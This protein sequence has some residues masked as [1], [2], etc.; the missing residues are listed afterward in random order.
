MSK[1]IPYLYNLFNGISAPSTLQVEATNDAKPLWPNSI[2]QMLLPVTEAYRIQYEQKGATP[3]GVFWSSTKNVLRRFEILCRIFHC[4]DLNKGTASIN[5]LGCGYGALFDY[6]EHHPV[7]INGK[8]MGYEI[9]KALLDSCNN[10]INDPR[11]S[12]HHSMYATQSADY[13]LVSG[14]FNMKLNA[15]DDDWLSYTE[16]SLK[17][18]WTDSKKG[19]AFNMLDITDARLLNGL[20]YADPDSFIKFCRK[21][22]TNNISLIIESDLPDFT[23][24]AL[25]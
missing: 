9:C 10:R 11:A 16:A 17:A 4:E 23:I 18:L 2:K 3:K 19:M 25:R 6:L 12:F 1:F 21:H 15:N 7:M 22:L 20:Y 24:H 8:Y 14:T 5:D 13:S